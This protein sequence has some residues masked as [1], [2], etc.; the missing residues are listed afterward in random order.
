MSERAGQSDAT[1]APADSHQ[2][3]A[4]PGE[5]TTRGQFFK[6]GAVGAA[7]LAAGAV[8]LGR[9]SPP[10]GAVT[11]GNMI[12][13]GTNT[14]T[15]QSN[16]TSLNGPFEVITTDATINDYPA[17]YGSN[18]TS[19][20]VFGISNSGQGVWGIAQTGGDGVRGYNQAALPTAASGFGVHG[21]SAGSASAVYGEALGSGGGAAG[22]WGTSVGGPS[23]ALG[24]TSIAV[25]PTSGAWLTGEF[26]VAG[27]GS[28]WYCYKAGSPGSW[29]QLNGGGVR[30]LSAPQRAYS[31]TDVGSGAPMNQG[32]T[33]TITI[34]GVVSGVPSSAVGVVVNVTVHNT[35]G[36]GYL[37]IYPAGASLPGTSSINWSA[38]GQ[39]IANGI[40]IG[41]GTGGAISVFANAGVPA[42]TP[43]TQVI[44][45]IN[46][47]IL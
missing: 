4:K 43:A 7:A 6:L 41:L 34:A 39:S 29:S 15:S 27:N 21:V 38:S 23:L 20:G 26:L 16:V 24:P 1:E 14:V 17:I 18:P 46:A 11:N 13:G 30:P 47:Y 9:S 33:R 8:E 45:D 12:I 42:G 40:T 19:I 28:L 36:G 22:L 5:G 31:S 10:A 44:V 35:V 3:S 2:D 32:E 25:P 37:T